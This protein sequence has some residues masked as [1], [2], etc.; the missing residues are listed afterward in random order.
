MLMDLEIV[1]MN[2]LKYILQH[3][4]YTKIF[5]ISILIIIVL[6]SNFIVKKSKYTGYEKEVVGLIYKIKINDNKR[7]IYIKGLEKLIIND[8]NKNV[9]IKLGDKIKVTGNMK[10]PTTSSIPNLFNYKKYLYYNKIYY[11]FDANEIKII[12]KNTN[13]LYFI[14][15]KINNRIDKIYKSKEYIKIFLLGDN[16][17]IEEDI[18]NS[19]RNNGIS[20]LFSISGMHISLFAGVLLFIFKRI[21]YN[22]YY[23][24]GMVIIFLM[25]YTT[26]VGSTPSAIRSLIMYILFAVNK[27]F[28]LKV[29][30]I[31]I[32]M[33]LLLI[34]LIINPYYIYDMAFQF[35]YLISF[36]LVL[37]SNKLK[38]IKSYFL[39]NLYIS[40][41]SFLVSFPICIYNFYQINVFSI[42]LNIFLVPLISI[43][44]FP[45]SLISFIIPKISYILNIFIIIFENISL[46]ISESKIGIISFAKPNILIILIYYIFIYL[47]LYNYKY[48]YIFLLM[49][50]HKNYLYFNSFSIISILDVGQG[51]SL[52]IQMPHNSYNVMI[53]TGGIN[54]NDYSIALTKTIPYLKSVGINKINSLILS[55]GDYDH[56]G[57]AIN[58]VNNFK[59]EKVIFNCGELNDLEQSL[60]KVLDKKKIPYYSCI[61]ELNIDDNKLYFL[62]N[63]D[64]GNE[65]DNSSV[66][67]TELNNHKFLFMG[68]AGVKVEEDLIKKYNLQDIDVLK[69]G[70]HGSRT[71]SGQEFISEINPK[72]SIIS[73][74]KNNRYGHPND[75]ILDN[76]SDS[77]IYR[78]DQEGSI[79][80]KIKNDKLKI[81]TCVP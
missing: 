18:M 44:I 24:Y 42:I 10:E 71:S 27:V 19:F 67:Y 14:K 69:V 37:F 76:L 60:I 63:K 65:N 77:K 55:H 62:N 9:E 25:F 49:F 53:D 73:V 34:M 3:R 20:H 4:C 80:F 21:S 40:T 48:F 16:S 30:K 22:N 23:N 66:I 54:Y 72:Y 36:S 7:I 70:H 1:Y 8:Y 68:D 13:I 56:M 35:S 52:L 31:D 15:E 17:L 58:L 39:K 6:Y 32:M 81:E 33:W 74:G 50:F 51:D 57:E 26:L 79:M 43:I 41:I 59:V 64:Y 46:I 45:L 29:S 12:N 38:T 75:N 2:R 78:T 28:N 61:K 47:F 5:V 11:L